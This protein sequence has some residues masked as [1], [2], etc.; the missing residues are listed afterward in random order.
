MISNYITPPSIAI[1]SYLATQI[2]FY[3]NLSEVKE[4][5]ILHVYNSYLFLSGRSQLQVKCPLS[6]LPPRKHQK[7]ALHQIVFQL[8][9]FLHLSFKCTLLTYIIFKDSFWFILKY[10]SVK[11]PVMF[12]YPKSNATQSFYSFFTP[13][14]N[15]F[16]VEFIFSKKIR[17]L[18]GKRK[19]F[20]L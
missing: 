8:R 6:Q 11:R 5:I 19:Q 13:S 12:L 1:T 9:L 15:S 2:A 10:Y 3:E 17:L 20:I 18:R 14:R 16:R 4:E 7:R